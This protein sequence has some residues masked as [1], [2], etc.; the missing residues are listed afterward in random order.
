MGRGA[1]SEPDT[2]SAAWQMYTMAVSEEAASG[3]RAQA[4]TPAVQQGSCCP[5]SP[6]LVAGGAFYHAG[7]SRTERSGAMEK[8]AF[9]FFLGRL[10]GPPGF[11]S[12]IFPQYF[13][14]TYCASIT[15][16]GPQGLSQ[17][18]SQRRSPLWVAFER[19]KKQMQT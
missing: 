14:S 7:F 6:F 1:Q 8:Q 11:H 19:N 5:K 17:K 13:L 12:S 10:T 15:V 4:K 18:N 9:P 16:Q 2:G 3:P